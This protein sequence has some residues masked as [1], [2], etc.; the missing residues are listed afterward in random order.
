MEV[1]SAQS[2]TQSL[3][4]SLGP[5][6]SH[7]AVLPQSY[8]QHPECQDQLD[9]QGQAWVTGLEMLLSTAGSYELL[10]QHL[11]G[12]WEPPAFPVPH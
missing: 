8:Q 3:E 7:W 9:F 10:P 2:W 11:L 6:L 12:T 5:L 1:G 4:G